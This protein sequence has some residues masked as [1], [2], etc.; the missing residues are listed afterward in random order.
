LITYGKNKGSFS[1]SYPYQD[2]INSVYIEELDKEFKVALV[3]DALVSDILGSALLAMM[4]IKHSVD[5]D[6]LETLLSSLHNFKGAKG[7]VERLSPNS[8]HFFLYNDYAHHPSEITSS[9]QA[10]HLLHPKSNIILLFFPHTVSRMRTLYGNFVSALSYCDTLIMFPVALSA[11]GD[12]SQEEAIEISKHLAKDCG[13]IYVDRI[14]EAVNIVSAVLHSK[15]V[16]IT[17]GAGNTIPIIDS[18]LEIKELP[19]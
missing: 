19:L 12:G 14:E 10:I 9:L 3:G 7:R 5:I 17:M 8:L 16:C 18:L 2:D 4:I 6:F 1:Y 15:D 13:G 11:R